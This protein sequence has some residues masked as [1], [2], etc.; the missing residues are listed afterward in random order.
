ML[1][2]LHRKGFETALIDRPG[3]SRVMVRMPALRMRDRDPPPHL[4]ELPIMSRPEEEMPML[5]HQAIGGDPYPGLA[6]GL[7]Q[8]LPKGG[9]VRRLL[10]QREPP[11]TTVQD[12]IR[13][14]PA[15]RRG[16][17]GILPSH[18]FLQRVSRKDSRPLFFVPLSTDLV[19]ASP[20]TPMAAKFVQQ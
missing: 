11:D 10:K 16:R 14:S 15:A 13:R 19:E 2:G 20:V 1:G 12:M 5:R 8:N 3:P 4:G 9:V 17:R 18:Q 7:G 6:M